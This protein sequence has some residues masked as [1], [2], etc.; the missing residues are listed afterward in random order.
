MFLKIT[1]P[2]IFEHAFS[3]GFE[4]KAKIIIEKRTS[5]G[6]IK[7]PFKLSKKHVFR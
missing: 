2:K 4:N 6:S 5:P 3:P 7:S 1:L